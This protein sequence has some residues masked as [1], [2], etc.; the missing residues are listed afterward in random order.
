RIPIQYALTWP[1]HLPSP[2]EP[3]DFK[4]LSGLTFE[5]PDLETFQGLSLAY[6][7]LR[8]GGSMPTV[9]NA[10]NEWANAVFRRGEIA[11]PEIY[12]ILREEMARHK[13][14]AAPTVA[15]IFA[16][17]EEI[18]AHCREKYGITL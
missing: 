2:A 11:F 6:E 12:D 9:F 10:A 16:A 7:A 5:Q 13:V 8:I 3:L 18:D 15:E 1:A 4:K 14:I 17:Q